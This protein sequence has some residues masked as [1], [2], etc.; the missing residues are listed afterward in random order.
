M[1]P[2]EFSKFLDEILTRIKFTLD[3]KSADYSTTQDKLFNFK[4][5]ASIDGITPIEALRGNNLKHQAS[6]T[7]GL[8]E[9]QQGKIR[10]LGWW[11]EKGIDH[12]NYTILLLALIKEQQE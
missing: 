11:L 4:L 9:L 7:Q 5:Q 10:P 6:I 2:N 8:N 1:N 12:I 3:S